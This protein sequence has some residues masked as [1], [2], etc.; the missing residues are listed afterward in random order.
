MYRLTLTRC[1]RRAFDWV[2]HRYATGDQWADLLIAAWD[3]AHPGYEESAGDRWHDTA[4][5]EF[6]VPESV[7]W[8][9]AEL[10]E[11]T[12]GRFPCFGRELREKLET[13]LGAIV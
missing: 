5:M 12:D 4:D 11:Q 2:G 9:L 10:A 3:A 7:A 13:F 8:Q 6:P 1:E